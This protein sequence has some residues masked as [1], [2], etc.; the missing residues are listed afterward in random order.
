MASEAERAGKIFKCVVW[1]LDNTLW[2]G[3]LLESASVHLKPGAAD[4][5]RSLDERGI[6]HSIASR[7]DPDAA[8]QKLR[9][10]GIMDYFLCPEIGWNSKSLAIARIRENLNI[11]LDSIL[12]LD[13]DPFERDEVSSEH[14][15]VTC[16][17]A[18]GYRSLP[19]DPRLNPGR[20]TE[21]S[22]RRRLIYREDMA[23][24]RDEEGF[25]GPKKEFLE[26]LR[27]RLTIA[28]AEVSDL[29]RAEELMARTNQLNAT[30]RV[31]EYDE[32]LALLASPDH[33][34][35]VCELEDRY[36]SYG[37]IGLALV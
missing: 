30:G 20:V 31:Y 13:D 22:R 32:L 12:F 2:D 37:K 25:R 29:Q 1:D 10:L 35:L 3:V 34:L 14:P 6:L 24:K 4:V 16:M 27:M 7:N 33:D 26:S 21:E 23:R 9:E 28:R 5:V 8:V 19:D 18:S 11:G 17:D 15:A 36:G